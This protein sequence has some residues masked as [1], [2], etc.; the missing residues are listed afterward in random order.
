MN[1]LQMEHVSVGYDGKALVKDIDISIEK[2]EIVSL[3][4]PNGSGKSTILKSIVRQL[5]L[6]AGTVELSGEDF[7]R[8]KESEAA[9]RMAVVLTDRIKAELMTCYDIVATGR[10]PYTGRFGRLSVDDEEKVEEAIRLVHAEEIGTRS[11]NAISDGQKQRIL[12]ARAIAQDPEIIVLDEPTSYLDMR[13]KLELLTILRRLSR[14]KKT[15]IVMS[16]HEIDLAQ[17]ISDRILCVREDHTFVWGT[18]QEI[19][20][21]DLLQELYGL[22][23][24]CIDP[25]FADLTGGPSR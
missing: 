18:P 9:T 19:F 20:R 22:D 12:L 21:D 17:R 10:Y 14:E 6:V 5:A 23:R 25:C 2:G 16:L 13:Y 3:I 1:H 11:F 15:T 24:A 4:G 7:S 8:M